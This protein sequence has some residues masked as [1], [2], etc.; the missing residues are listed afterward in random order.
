[1]KTS[2]KMSLTGV[3]KTRKLTKSSSLNK[4]KRL[5]IKRKWRKRGLE[6]KKSTMITRLKH[7]WTKCERP[8]A[9]K[10]TPMILILKRGPLHSLSANPK[11]LEVEGAKKTLCK[12]SEHS[13]V[14]ILLKYILSLSLKLTSLALLHPET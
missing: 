4:C 6:D 8:S 2:R 5:W 13:Q 11:E 12:E 9:K 10:K 3:N 7:S 14:R 1:M